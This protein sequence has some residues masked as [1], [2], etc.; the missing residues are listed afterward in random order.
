MTGDR[1]M[2]MITIQSVELVLDL[3]NYLSPHHEMNTGNIW[4]NNEVSIKQI[5]Q[6]SIQANLSH[7]YLPDSQLV[8]FSMMI[9]KV[10]VKVSTKPIGEIIV[11]KMFEIK[12][13]MMLKLECRS[14]Y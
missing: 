5:L 3:M 12:L 9:N 7:I 8:T 14:D 11:I 1:T 2:V 10:K 4:Q 6:L 13:E